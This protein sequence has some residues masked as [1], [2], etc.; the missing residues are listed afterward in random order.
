MFSRSIVDHLRILLTGAYIASMIICGL[1]FY[2]VYQADKLSSWKKCVR[3]QSM[4]LQELEDFVNQRRQSLQLDL[5]KIFENQQQNAWH[6]S[7][8]ELFQKRCNKKLWE[9]Y[10][11]SELVR[12]RQSDTKNRSIQ[13]NNTFLTRLDLTEYLKKNAPNIS[14]ELR[15][16]KD[17]SIF[18]GGYN[19][20]ESLRDMDWTFVRV[21]SPTSQKFI[22]PSNIPE[23]IRQALGKTRRFDRQPLLFETR[24]TKGEKSIIYWISSYYSEI[25][26]ASRISFIEKRSN[27][28]KSF[29]QVWQFP[30]LFFCLT[31][32]IFLR[33]RRK[34]L[35]NLKSKIN[36]CFGYLVNDKKN[37][38]SPITSVEDEIS[39]LQSRMYAFDKRI[40][41]KWS[42]IKLSLGLQTILNKSEKNLDYYLEEAD[43]F[44]RDLDEKYR[45][46]YLDETPVDQLNKVIEIPLNTQQ[47]EFLVE[48]LNRRPR[49]YLFFPRLE[50]LD[51]DIIA[52]IQKQ[53]TQ[54]IEKARLEAER[55]TTTALKSD[56]QL[57]SRI[58]SVLMPQGLV[59]CGDSWEC[60]FSSEASQGITGEF[61][62]V[63]NSKG[64]LRFYLV[65][66]YDSG[67]KASVMAMVYKSFLDFMMADKDH[68]EHVLEDL[69]RFLVEKS[70]DDALANI[71]IGF[72]D[73]VSGK[74]DYVCAGVGMGFHIVNNSYERLSADYPPVGYEIQKSIKANSIHIEQNQILYIVSAEAELQTLTQQSSIHFS[75][76]M[77]IIQKNDQL[78]LVDIVSQIDNRIKTV[79]RFSQESSH[80]TQLVFRRC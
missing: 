2:L 20:S 14:F 8:R 70:Y 79:S 25:L 36:D 54:M 9:E 33:I 39:W 78:S 59:D 13:L 80:L 61:L 22:K 37:E 32:F 48:R 55:A 56:L 40:K 45:V 31:L 21:Y 27:Y 75:E 57:A 63:V 12:I 65:D 51:A 19:S 23:Q 60:A 53:F 24:K 6:K 69:Q 74:L 47:Q 52:I 58:Q 68:P 17:N 16:L 43:Y 30:L 28:M 66:L 10:R 15:F 76:I 4:F 72:M 34:F 50:N 26:G 77:S 29:L 42:L 11:N 73:I 7:I 5:Q 1:V 62:D 44:L 35:D 38:L 67:I 71:F 49:L 3:S 41:E 46:H 18:S 64:S